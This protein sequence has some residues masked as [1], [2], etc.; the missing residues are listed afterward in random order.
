MDRTKQANMFNDFFY[1]SFTE[2]S[3]ALA[4]VNDFATGVNTDPPVITEYLS[5]SV[6]T[7]EADLQHLNAAK[8]K[9]PDNLP[10][11]LFKNVA[12]ALAPSGFTKFFALCMGEG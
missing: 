6:A 2:P 3:A 11:I 7:I 5:F 12:K 8:A 1:S 9:S 4:T 10:P